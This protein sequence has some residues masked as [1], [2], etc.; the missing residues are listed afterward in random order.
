MSP[1]ER[2][3]HNHHF[4]TP[5]V[6][7]L[8][9]HGVAASIETTFG[10]AGPLDITPSAAEVPHLEELAEKAVPAVRAKAVGMHVLHAATTGGSEHTRSHAA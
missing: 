5:V 9:G 1:A 3:I 10:S 2:S 6:R 4:E 8:P 7:E